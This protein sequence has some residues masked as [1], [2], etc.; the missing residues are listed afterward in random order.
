MLVIP[1]ADIKKNMLISRKALIISKSNNLSLFGAI[2]SNWN[3]FCEENTRS[4]ATEVQEELV[5][6]LTP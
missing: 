3:Y 4:E 1:I 2:L 5:P 6:H